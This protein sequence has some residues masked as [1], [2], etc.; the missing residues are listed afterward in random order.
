MPVVEAETVAPG[1][2]SAFAVAAG[3]IEVCKRGGR[4]RMPGEEIGLFGNIRLL[5]ATAR[6]REAAQPGFRRARRECRDRD[7]LVGGC[8]CTLVL[9]GKEVALHAAVGEPVS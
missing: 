3:L 9:V 8:C 7:Y 6:Y 1:W 2:D 4:R 5:K